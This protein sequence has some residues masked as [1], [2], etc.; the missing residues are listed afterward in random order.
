MER[1]NKERT[2]EEHAQRIAR[3]IAKDKA[4]AAKIAQAGIDYTY[5]GLEAQLPPKPK[6]IK[7]N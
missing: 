1:H 6:K 3:L 2:P 5:D 7:F 4:R